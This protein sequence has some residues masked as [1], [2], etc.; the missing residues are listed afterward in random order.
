MIVW[1]EV[2]VPSPKAIWMWR[3]VG[4]RLAQSISKVALS[5]VAEIDDEGLVFHARFGMAS[6]GPTTA[7]LPN[8]QNVIERTR[9]AELDETA[10]AHA[11]AL[12]IC[13]IADVRSTAE[14]RSHVANALV[15]DF[16]VGLK[17]GGVKSGRHGAVSSPPISA[18]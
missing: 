6:V 7:F 16:V 9:A 14:Y 10:V 3:K 18:R 13:P 8:V 17:T 2:K 12:D 5:A 4:T 1:I 11:L 15:R